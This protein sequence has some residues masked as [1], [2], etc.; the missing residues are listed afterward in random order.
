LQLLKYLQFSLVHREAEFTVTSLHPIVGPPIPVAS[1]ID[2]RPTTVAFSDDV[3]V[4]AQLPYN[5]FRSLNAQAP[6]ARNKNPITV[7]LA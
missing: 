5:P 6:A 7:P 4:D 2:G 1:K 3:Q